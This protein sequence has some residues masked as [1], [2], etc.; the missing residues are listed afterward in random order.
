MKLGMRAD[1]AEGCLR[2]GVVGIEENNVRGGAVS[3][4]AEKRIIRLAD[5][6]LQESGQRSTAA[7]RRPTSQRRRRGHLASQRR[8]PIL[9]RMRRR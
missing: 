7:R 3:S 6:P 4:K 1:A 8:N 5:C 9:A 2:A